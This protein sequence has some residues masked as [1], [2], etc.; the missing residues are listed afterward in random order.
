MPAPRALPAR[1]LLLLPLA[2]FALG[3]RPLL[4]QIE[5]VTPHG[6]APAPPATRAQADRHFAEK[7]YALALPEY[8][9]LLTRTPQAAPDRTLIEYRIAV[10]LG[11]A[12]QWDAAFAAWDAF[13]AAHGQ[14]P[15]WAGRAHYQRALLLNLAP[16][17]GYKVGARLYR[18][19]DYPHVTGAEKPEQVQLQSDDRKAALADFEAA[20]SAYEQATQPVTFTVLLG[21]GEAGKGPVF[22]Q[23]KDPKSRYV[24]PSPSTPL[25]LTVY[26]R[27]TVPS[28]AEQTDLCFDLA[29]FLPGGQQRW[30]WGGQGWGSDDDWKLAKK[31]DWAI[32]PSQAYDSAWP[33]PKKVLFL[34]A[35][36]EMLNPNA[37][38]PRVLAE[39]TRALYVAQNADSWTRREWVQRPGKP[40]E[41]RVTQTVP[42]VA[43]DPAAILARAAD[44]YP[45]DP[46]APQIVLILAQWAERGGDSVAA[47]KL[48]RLLASRYPASKWAPDAGQAIAEILRPTV[49]LN[50]GGPQPAG[51]PAT[52]TVSSRN[53]QTITLR[54][55]KVP[56]E[57]V[58]TRPARLAD[59]DQLTK[60]STDFGNLANAATLG[61]LVAQW[62]NQTGDTGKHRL[63]G[64]SAT[65][66]LSQPGA[67][68][69]VADGDD[70]KVRA[71]AMV[72]ISD[73]A[74]M[75]KT[76][77]D[78]V[79]CFVADASSGRPVPGADVVVRQFYYD[80]QSQKNTV[81]NT[82]GVTGPDGTLLVPTVK[83]NQSNVQT[84]AFASAPQGRYA[85]T[86]QG[87]WYGGGSGD[88][89][90]EIKTYAYTDRP[91]YR[92]GQTVSLRAL[93]AR[94]EGG[95]NF[96]PLAVGTPV[97]VWVSGPRGG[98]IYD[99]TLTASRFGSINGSFDL[100][101]GAALG[102]YTVSIDVPGHNEVMD[103][104]SRFRVEE[105][106]RPEYLVAVTPSTT[107]ARFGDRVTA[108]VKATYYAGPPVAGA[109][110][111]YHVFRS[112]YYPNYRF[113]QAYDWL[114]HADEGGYANQNADGG[115]LVT[116]GEGVT[117]AHG[118]LAVSF[119]ALKGTRAY[120]GDYAY[121]VKADV[122]D[123]S[124]R[125]VGGEG[126][127]HVTRQ[128]FYAYLNVPNGFYQLGDK[129]QIELRTLNPDAQPVSTSG[130]LTAYLQTCDG[131]KLVETAVHTQELT[132]DADGKALT[133]WQASE[134]G[135]YRLEF[136]A[137]DKFAQVVKAESSVWIT[138]GDLGLRRFHVGGITL[139][140]DKTTYQEGETAHLL[141]VSDQPDNWVLLTSEAGSETLSRAVVHVA[142]R[143]RT[144][145]VP[146]TR[147]DAPN[148]AFGAVAV[149]DYQFFRWQQEVFVP[150][151]RQ[152]LNLAVTS[153]KAEYKPGDVGTFHVRATDAAGRPVAS[154]VSLAV[155]DSSVYYIQK[156]YAPDIR[157]F[158]YGQR[159]A[160][161]INVDTSDSGQLQGAF[162]SDLPVTPFTVHGIHI[163]EMGRLPDEW[164]YPY[165]AYYGLYGTYGGRRRFGGKFGAIGALFRNRGDDSSVGQ[166]VITAIEQRTN[167]QPN[168][169]YQF[170]GLVFGQ[171]GMAAGAARSVHIRGS[172]FN[173]SGFD[174][175]GI[176][177]TPGGSRPAPAR[178]RRDFRETAFWTPAVVTS[179]VDGTATVTVHFPDT[180]TT[181]KATA[182]GLTPDVRVGAGES[183]ATTNKHLLVRLE[184][185]RF[186]VQR[187]RVTL[188]AIVRNDLATAKAVR[189]SLQTNADILRPGGPDAAPTPTQTVTVPAHGEKR[190]DWDTQVVGDGQATV[191]MVAQTDEESDA[192][193]QTFPALA[194][195]VQK[196]VTA[197]GVLQS[198]QNH[199]GLTVTLP[200]DRRAGS[201]ALLVQINP[202]L[203]ATTLD[204]LPYLADYPYGC[205][206]QTLSRFLPSVV[207]AHTLKDAGVNLDTLHARALA[208]A[209]REK[210]GTPF[211][212]AHAAALTDD[213]TGYSY[214]SGTPGVLKT[215]A[216][217][218]ELGHTDRWR[219]PV[220]NP[221]E[222]QSMVDDGLSR[223]VSMQRADGGWGW[224]GGSAQSDPY[225]SAYVVYGLAMARAA[226]VAVPEGVLGR[227]NAYLAGDLKNR[228][229]ERDL[230]VWEAFALSQTP[231]T[232]PA[233]GR[234]VVGVVYGERARLSPYGQALLALTLHGLGRTAEAETVC[235]NLRNTAR[236]D[237]ENGTASWAPPPQGWWYWY[238]DDVET[239]A[240]ALKAYTAILPHDDLTPMLVKWLV[241][242]QHGS[243]WHSTKAT[244][245]AVYALTD[246][247]KANNELAPDYTV[248]VSL[249]DKIS[250][251]FTVNRDN[252]LLF[253]NQFL[254]PDALLADG[255]QTVSVTKTGAGRLYYSTAV[256]YI[257]TE[258][259]IAHVGTEMKVQR[260]YYRL[261][262]KTKSVADYAGGAFNVLDYTRAELADGASLKS[263]D[264][265][266]VELVLDS[267]NEY[268]YCCFEDMK[269]A[270]C[271]PLALRS[272]ESYGD[273]LCSDM[274]LRDTKTAFFVDHLP[275]GTRVLRY[276]LR[277]EVPGAFHA[278][279]T[280]GYAMYAP[281][282]R[283][284]SDGWH[285][286]VTDAERSASAR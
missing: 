110:V 138:G 261:T 2:A 98:S 142:G 263:G 257:T 162:E 87:Y 225:M 275:Q 282:V 23:I 72:L 230:A 196:F 113:P 219:G 277:A 195:G 151:A 77:R 249:G 184:S 268:D 93:L 52:L 111:S 167:A 106:K 241:Q 124:R 213:P 222:L 164:P 6:P 248:K 159:R 37:S 153:D 58:L 220:F 192:V 62:T 214:P 31:T 5:A 27:V 229:D 239:D 38:H 251:T 63:Y 227:G 193:E 152:F 137:T 67:Y 171:P 264:L 95:T 160:V 116:S 68:L 10:A 11:A 265:I 256:Q 194:Y 280:N 49:G 190:V 154:E 119:T 245:M 271:E 250:R 191:R 173:Q 91:V 70:G 24:E 187:D 247:I 233:S 33:Q 41:W 276:R 54:A 278:L 96:K 75:K 144:L 127:L 205:V 270:G 105:Y 9:S 168:N 36:A 29:K 243:I 66:P 238:N 169:L 42:Y 46:Q 19:S 188:S 223:L 53:L 226:G 216:L 170:S 74:V 186:F 156:E 43:L 204:A 30:Q 218:G 101:A 103:G 89:R 121:T 25:P 20:V 207:V 51:R 252:A 231:Q 78:N 148:F 69:V 85:L 79:L 114:Y 199:A 258:E 112:P 242:N 185:P 146:I 174:V 165:Y 228:D 48:Y 57:T 240:W 236:I 108:T 115:E 21:H 86:G 39:I 104:G 210:V 122:V 155:V 235:R 59:I 12:Q 208:L 1:A 90:A 279:P 80:N 102:E 147:A 140:T 158:Y 4:A 161:N 134:S 141:I 132:T 117:D 178:V 163:V 273:G 136:K 129:A 253:D 176:A 197:A 92:P 99:Q 224:W 284:L 60:F 50:T 209:A 123:S 109:K 172:D 76:D 120:A 237:A 28:A 118:A 17:Q 97:H 285:V 22:V 131:P 32:H 255:P 232:F 272:G 211:G 212:Q 73:L 157:L 259:N 16:H 203:A 82:R 267:K 246:Y 260:R 83:E 3:L 234:A 181:W 200:H 130:T 189:V 206:E 269:P 244:A 88:T 35:R 47:L 254:V 64:V 177:I 183:E 8:Q 202:S 283:A 143:A 100:P 56:L 71:G 128:A 139:L 286:S 7:S 180:L 201:A 44:T 145:D 266:E 198:D 26:E 274:E 84:E 40:G 107:Q 281:E 13:L 262:P 217:A 61:P 215:P 94:R 221:A 179:A 34:L 166:V 14:V 18:G 15:V 65:T 126:I 81:R 149:R 125:Q 150:P 135:Q 45:H 55:Y 175:D 182:R 133:T